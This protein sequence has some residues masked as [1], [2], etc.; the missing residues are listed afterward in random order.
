MRTIEGILSQMR[1]SL[2]ESNSDLASFPEY[3]NLYAIFR[4]VA[5]SILEQDVKLNTINSNLYLNSAAGEALDSKASEFNLVRR[6]GTLAKGAL[7]VLGINNV[8]PSSTILTD[9]NTGLQFS[10]DNQV[11]MI[12]SKGIA[13][14]TSTEYTELANLKAGTELYSSIYPSVRF[15]VGNSFN[16]QTNTYQGNL[17]GGRSKETDD[18]L[19]IRISTTIQSL[20]LSNTQA[21]EIAARNIAGVTKLSIIENEPS[22]GYITVYINNTETKFLSIVKNRLDLIKP[23]GTA[24]IVKTF[25]SVPINI[26]VALEVYNNTN[27]SS[28]QTNIR[29]NIQEYINNLNPGA[30][31]NKESIAAY[32]LKIPEVY[33]VNVINPTGN[34]VTKDSELLSLNNFNISYI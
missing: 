20:S 21:L 17:L 27:T 7:T 14:I 15:I 30:T 24:I 12:S 32:I 23:I 3:G 22:L 26:N 34:I 5:S 29:S 2:E 8:I 31:L 33:N 10:I 6:S 25:T 1:E 13:S 11:I 9:R 19:K 16:I 4:A 18:E 28:L